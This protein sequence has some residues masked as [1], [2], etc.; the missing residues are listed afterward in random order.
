MYLSLSLS[1][2]LSVLAVAVAGDCPSAEYGSHSCSAE[3]LAKARET[4]S[5][6]VKEAA[7]APVS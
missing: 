6:A 5:G 3:A 2:Y 4:S 1:L 7:E